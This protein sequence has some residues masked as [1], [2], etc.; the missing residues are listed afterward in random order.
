MGNQTKKTWFV[1]AD[2][3]KFKIFESYSPKDGFQIIDHAE[4]DKAREQDR[5]LAAD[6]PG[7]GQTIGTGEHFAMENKINFHDQ[8]KQ[9]FLKGLAQRLDKEKE[10]A[11]FD[12]LIIVAPPKAMAQ[13][14]EVLS[15][16]SRAKIVT[17]LTKDLT[18]M[19]DSQLF[20]YLIENVEHW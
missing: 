11:S 6:K 8:A 1:I 2:G 5:E 14:R 20:P 12:Q 9:I 18:N 15:Q 13:L 7:R 19:P 3:A 17:S 16:G 4:N 10:L